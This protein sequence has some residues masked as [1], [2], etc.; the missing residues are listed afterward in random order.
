M[1]A[2]SGGFWV[3]KDSKGKEEVLI[4][5]GI[6]DIK[7]RSLF[8]A[9][10]EIQQFS[11][12]ERDGASVPSDVVTLPN[13]FSFME[14]GFKSG[15]VSVL[16]SLISVPLM[17]GVFNNLIK[18]FNSSHPHFT[19]SAFLLAASVAPPVGFALVVSHIIS[20][21][22]RGETTSKIVSYLTGSL[23]TS[24][25]LVSAVAALLFHIIY[26]KVLTAAGVYN[27]FNWM[28]LVKGS[29]FAARAANWILRFK[30]VLIPSAWFILLVHIIS[31]LVIVAGN[32][33]GKR[34]TRLIEE[35][36]KEWE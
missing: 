32:L 6:V 29:L 7:A 4:A 31:S 19:D 22:Y 33:I 21:A 10:A 1:E 9:L 14:V 26:Y 30:E 35:F 24:K 36:K 20:K 16:I 27:F 17:F 28:P 5:G 18:V 8:H 11:V 34:K 25:L 3:A 2:L 15:F 23:V 12:C 13:L